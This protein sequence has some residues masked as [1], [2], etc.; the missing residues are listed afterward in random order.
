MTIVN[1]VRL[2]LV[3]RGLFA[4]MT[5][6]FGPASP[7]YITWVRQQ[8][9]FESVPAAG[10]VSLALTAGPTPFSNTQRRGTAVEAAASVPYTVTTVTVGVRYGIEV[11]GFLYYVDSDGSSTATT[12][13]DA[14]VAQIEADPYVS[15]TASTLSTD[16]LTLTADFVGGLMTLAEVG[17]ITR[18]SPVSSGQSV[19][20]VQGTQ[21]MT[22]SIEAYSKNRT[23]RDGAASMIAVAESALQTQ[24][25][26][27]LLTQYGMSVGS[28]SAPIDLS[29]AVDGAWETRHQFSAQ[30]YTS[31]LWADPVDTIETV[32]PAFSITFAA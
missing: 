22:I 10:L 21:A 28:K 14:L 2:D 15:V 24:S 32:T 3:E 26:V 9:A 18:G 4:A 7:P 29:F 13:R 11:N 19:L 17:S 23:L 27:D 1:P 5:A 30:V 6:A 16:G 8:Q 12:I 25:I 20:V 31:C